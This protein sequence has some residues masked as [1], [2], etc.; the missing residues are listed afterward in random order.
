MLPETKGR[1]YTEIRNCLEINKFPGIPQISSSISTAEPDETDL[2]VQRRANRRRFVSYN[3]QRLMTASYAS[4]GS[5]RN[6]GKVDSY[7]T[8]RNGSMLSANSLM[9]S[10]TPNFSPVSPS[11]SNFAHHRY[12]VNDELLLIE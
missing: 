5:F 12:S 11:M 9:T 2:L 8:L 1:S 4:Y 7:R 10:R 3:S 6:I